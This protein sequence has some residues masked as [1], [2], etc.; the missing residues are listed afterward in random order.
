MRPSGASSLFH[1][2]IQI[3]GDSAFDHH[4]L[5]GCGNSPSSCG[6]GHF[7]AVVEADFTG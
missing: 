4:A 5:T 6:K 7:V 1:G 2:A 3:S